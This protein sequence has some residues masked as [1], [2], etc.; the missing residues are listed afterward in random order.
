MCLLQISPGLNFCSVTAAQARSCRLLLTSPF[1]S[2]HLQQLAAPRRA[3]PELLCSSKQLGEVT[4]PQER[5]DRKSSCGQGKVLNLASHGSP[6]TDFPGSHKMVE[7][8]RLPAL[9]IQVFLFCP[10]P[11]NKQDFFF[12]P[13]KFI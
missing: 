8:P 12:S 7:V 6:C 5:Q 9:L 13:L 1:H 2:C 3:Q 4:R 11:S 10:L